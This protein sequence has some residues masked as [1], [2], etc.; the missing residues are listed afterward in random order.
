MVGYNCESQTFDLRR[1]KPNLLG[2]VKYART[3]VGIEGTLTPSKSTR[4]RPRDGF[5][6]DPPH[7]MT[8]D[9]KEAKIK[10]SSLKSEPN[11]SERTSSGECFNFYHVVYVDF[12]C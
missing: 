6:L 4:Q 7:K 2:D 10:R 9:A 3:G 11:V 12:L 1:Q 8:S 5:Q